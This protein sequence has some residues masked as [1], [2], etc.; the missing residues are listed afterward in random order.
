ML[1]RILILGGTG[2]ARLAAQA[3]VE[4]GYHVVTSLAGVTQNPHL[5]AGET[6]VGGFGGPEGLATYLATK[7]I[8]LVVDA[9]HP[10]ALQISQH[11]SAACREADVALLRLE[12]PAWQQP[13]DGVWVSVSDFTSALAAVPDGAVVLLTTGRKNLSAL[14]SRPRLRGLV[15]CIEPPAL[16][17]PEGWSLLQQRPPF[18]F[19][20]ETALMKEGRITQL[21]TKNAGGQS[22]A[23]KLHAAMHLG[24]NIIMIERPLKPPDRT[25]SSVQELAQAVGRFAFSG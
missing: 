15:R 7:E 4:E 25:V 20:Q 18:T 2:E 16:P 13:G 9:T 22:T 12:R 5:P 11:A 21:V 10:F 3:L 23:A 6:R 1:R 17:L 14:A 24:I 8:E 19:D